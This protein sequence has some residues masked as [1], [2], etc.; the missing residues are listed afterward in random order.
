MVVVIMTSE[1]VESWALK[2]EILLASNMKLE[3]F[4]LVA[5]D[6]DAS[7]I[8]SS[9]R[10][11]SSGLEILIGGLDMDTLDRVKEKIMSAHSNK[12]RLD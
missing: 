11:L 9:L 6:E 7:I 10:E 1:I 3:V 12:R 5:E 2:Q 8:R 4:L